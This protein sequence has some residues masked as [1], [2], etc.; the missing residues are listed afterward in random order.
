MANDGSDVL[1][2][3]LVRIVDRIPEGEWRLPVDVGERVPSLVL[4]VGV[5]FGALTERVRFRHAEYTV[6]P[7][8]RIWRDSYA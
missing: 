8:G 5:R 7:L 4:D 2:Q 6:T 1:A 3:A